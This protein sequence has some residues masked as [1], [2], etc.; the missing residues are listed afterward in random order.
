MLQTEISGKH[1]SPL[2]FCFLSLFFYHSSWRKDQFTV[3]S[4]KFGTGNAQA[5]ER[6]TLDVNPN[7]PSRNP[8]PSSKTEG[9]PL[10][11]DLGVHPGRGTPQ[12]PPPPPPPPPFVREFLF[13]KRV[14]DGNLRCLLFVNKKRI[15]VRSQNF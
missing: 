7:S 11:A 2:Y 12:P 14:S 10:R 15:C 4:L 9:D 6:T 8:P 3:L 1:N 5:E 13:C